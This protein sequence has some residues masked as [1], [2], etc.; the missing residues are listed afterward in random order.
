MSIK[1]R[2]FQNVFSFKIA[3]ILFFYNNQN[4][5]IDLIFKIFF[6]NH[7]IIYFKKN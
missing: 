1:I 6:T 5:A 4:H 7:Y 3:T 2:K